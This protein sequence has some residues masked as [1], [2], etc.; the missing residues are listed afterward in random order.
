MIQ[1]LLYLDTENTGRCFSNPAIIVKKNKQS[2][3]LGCAGIVPVRNLV[4]RLDIA[5]LL[6]SHISVFRAC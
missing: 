4:E 6:D 2:P 5:S 3:L 1:D